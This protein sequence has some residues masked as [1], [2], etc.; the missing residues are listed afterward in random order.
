MHIV[1]YMNAPIRREWQLP[2]NGRFTCPSQVQ[3]HKP[4]MGFVYVKVLS[5]CIL[6]GGCSG[7]EIVSGSI[8][9]PG[10]S[11]AERVDGTRFLYYVALPVTKIGKRSPTP[12]TSLRLQITLTTLFHRHFG[13]AK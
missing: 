3:T 6:G 5:D 2:L 12:D 10:R 8:T 9:L 4:P 7:R 13:R 11:V 1:N